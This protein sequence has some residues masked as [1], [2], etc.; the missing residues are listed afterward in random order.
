MMESFQNKPM[1][2]YAQ[3]ELNDKGITLNSQFMP[4]DS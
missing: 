3:G 4:T 1:L 2:D